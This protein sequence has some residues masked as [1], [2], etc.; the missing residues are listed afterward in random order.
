MFATAI[1]NIPSI[2]HAR[3]PVVYSAAKVALLECSR[4]DECKDWADKAEALASYARQ[5]DDKEMWNTADRI[6]S[7]A[8]RRC[9]ELLRELAP[10]D[11][12]GPSKDGKAGLTISRNKVAKDAG[13]SIHQKRTALRVAN[14]PEADFERAVESDPPATVKKLAAFG[15][16]PVLIDLRGRDPKEFALSTQAQGQLRRFAEFI[17]ESD[18]EIAVRGAFPRERALMKQNI[19]AIS[20]WLDK[21][22]KELASQKEN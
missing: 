2:S 19:L 20:K 18:P 14:V 4:I 13:L 11:K 5:S 12:P 15:K 3:L 8:I 17:S 1:A 22:L 16:K 6:R 10:K 21:L 7:R 9:G